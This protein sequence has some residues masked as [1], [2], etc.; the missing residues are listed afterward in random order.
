MGTHNRLLSLG[1][2]RF[3]EVIAID[4]EA[5]APLQP[6]WFELDRPAMQERLAR[7]PALIHWVAR[8]DDIEAAVEATTTGVRP[9][10]LPLARGA[11]RWKI[12]VPADG[13]LPRG[14]VTPTI[15]Q[16][17]SQHPT[18]VLPDAGCRLEALVLR[19]PDAPAILHAL[20]F[21][22]LSPEDPVQAHHE[23]VGLEVRI[24]TPKSTVEIRE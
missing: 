14:G 7:G 20:R 19:D 10:L 23:G 24:R 8:S 18:D 4:P 17:F 11:F 1:P 15:I 22:G 9:E 13:S 21:A 12:A 3:L 6:R 16:W 5:A 2:G